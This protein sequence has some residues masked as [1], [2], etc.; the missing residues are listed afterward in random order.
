MHCIYR[1]TTDRFSTEQ[2]EPPLLDDAPQTVST[3]VPEAAGSERR[4]A[5]PV[6]MA[7]GAGPSMTGVS[8]P[9][10]LA[11]HLERLHAEELKTWISENSIPLAAHI[12]GKRKVR[13][14][15]DIRRF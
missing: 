14:S 7:L 13:F 3:N 8:R 12:G 6:G 10:D 1:N 9:A 2:S 11:K 15:V 5:A 4:P